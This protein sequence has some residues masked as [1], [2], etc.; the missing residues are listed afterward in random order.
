MR[1]F[2]M[3]KFEELRR[4]EAENPQLATD[5]DAAL[6]ERHQRELAARDARQREEERQR[7]Q[8]ELRA[9]LPARLVHLGAPRRAVKAWQEGITETPAVKAVRRMSA[10][11]RTLCLLSGGVGTGKTVAAVVAM[12]ERVLAD[13]DE[14]QPALFVRAAECARM[15]LY[16]ADSKRLFRQMLEAGVLVVDDLGVEFLGEGSIWR[17]LLEEVLD[18]RYGDMLPT[19]LTTNMDWPG[20]SA[21]YGARV[22]DR[23]RH[24]G[25]ADGSGDTSLRQKGQG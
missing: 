3:S 6:V 7:R 22:A 24:S 1:T 9:E 5:W 20:F 19:V 21:R 10:E 2:D 8:V 18:V 15:G 13:V 4:W 25:I 23:I 11:K 17:S 12:A 16:D 14:V